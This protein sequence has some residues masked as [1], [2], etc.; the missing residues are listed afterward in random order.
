MS[1]PRASF[2]EKELT[3][4]LSRSYGPGRYDPDYEEHAID[5]PVGYVRW[6]EQRNMAEFVRLLAQGRI[7]VKPL[8]TDR[9]PVDDAAAAYAAVSRGGA[10]LGVLLEYAATQLRRECVFVGRPT[11][12]EPAAGAVGVGFLGAGKFATATLL[13]A[14]ARDSRFAARGVFTNSGLSARDVAERHGFSFVSGSADEVLAD[15]ETL[16]VVVASRHSS[17]AALAIAAMR[18]GKTVFIEKPL[19]MTEAELAEVAIVQRDT[20]AAATVGFNRRF[21]PH[22]RKV[23]SALTGRTSPATILI[24]V[25]AG[26]VPATHWTQQ[27][28]DGGGRIVGELCHFVDL[29]ACLAGAAPQRVFAAS[30]AAHRPPLLSDDLSV[31]LSFADGSVATIVYTAAGDPAYHKERVEVFWAGKVM[32][33]DDFKTLS[34]TQGGRTHTTRSQMADKGHGAEMRAFLDLASGRPVPELSF[35][36]CVASMAATFKVVESLVTGAPVVTPV[37]QVDG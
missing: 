2:Y 1:V 16:A 13:P 34:L 33:I 3:L 10:S 21:A 32:M 19:A 24:R 30:A 27:P 5:Y 37:I 18:A 17:H 20:S 25:N 26:A 23:V 12:G 15:P 9:F 28:E 6:T 35:A 36:D 8:I 22:V 4:K 14:L 29:A 11:T 31:T 7:D